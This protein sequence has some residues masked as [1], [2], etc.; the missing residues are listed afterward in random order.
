MKNEFGNASKEDASILDALS[1]TTLTSL[2]KNALI[3]ADYQIV[4]LPANE[5]TNTGGSSGGGNPNN[6]PHP[7]GDRIIY[8]YKEDPV[9]SKYLKDVLDDEIKFE[10][11]FATNVGTKVPGRSHVYYY[12]FSP[13]EDSEVKIIEPIG[14]KNNRTIIMRTKLGFEDFCKQLSARKK[15][16]DDFVRS[17][18]AI[19]LNHIGDDVE[20]V[21]CPN[22]LR[23]IVKA[24]LSVGNCKNMA[25]LRNALRN[26]NAGREAISLDELAAFVTKEINIS[27]LDEAKKYIVSI[28]KATDGIPGI[29]LP[30]LQKLVTDVSSLRD[31]TGTSS[32]G[33]TAER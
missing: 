21:N 20:T 10:G 3:Q 23:L 16:L 9:V 26:Q 17:G 25:E 15:C 27:D 18:E 8:N 14:Q 24:I 13:S 22:R 12:V 28:F 7:Q 29:T 2:N 4:D 19:R 31:F 30:R 6:Q 11:V 1:E 32:D 33:P 5:S